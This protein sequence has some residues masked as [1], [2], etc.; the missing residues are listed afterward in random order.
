VCVCL[1]LCLTLFL[2]PLSRLSSLL[3]Y[4]RAVSRGHE[5]THRVN[6]H[7]Y[8]YRRRLLPYGPRTHSLE[9]NTGR[10]Y[11]S[12]ALPSLESHRNLSVREDQ[13]IAR[14][15]C[16]HHA[17][18]CQRRSIKRRNEHM[19][20]AGKGT[21]ST[22]PRLIEPREGS[23]SRRYRRA[24]YTARPCSGFL[25]SGRGLCHSRQRARVS[26][27]QS[28]CTPGPSPCKHTPSVRNDVS[29]ASC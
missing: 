19:H 17:A 14:L 8:H 3:S 29:Q 9:V 10:L 1:S 13:P 25:S 24:V 11:I 28:A 18:I 22:S 20:C 16:I 21:Y 26:C 2:S 23:Q 12:L 7:I 27:P 15:S 5:K 4:E 6:T